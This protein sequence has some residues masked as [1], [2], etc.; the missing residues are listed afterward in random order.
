LVARVGR[1]LAGRPGR[2]LVTGY[3]DSVPLRRS[4]RFADNQELSEARA[5]TVAGLLAGPMEG[6]SRLTVS[7]RG[8]RDPIGDNRTA[9]GRARNRRVEIVLLKVRG[10]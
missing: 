7:G 5:T 1:E 6:S 2:V 4:T 8:E 10:G 9:D 3:T